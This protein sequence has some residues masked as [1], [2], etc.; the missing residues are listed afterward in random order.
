MRACGSYTPNVG[1]ERTL[2]QQLRQHL[3]QAQQQ[4]VIVLNRG[5]VVVNSRK[6]AHVPGAGT[7]P[8]DNL[9]EDFLGE[10][11]IFSVAF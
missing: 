5:L 9:N 1:R 4:A 10:E 8:I 2:H 3:Q 11:S 6:V 7:L